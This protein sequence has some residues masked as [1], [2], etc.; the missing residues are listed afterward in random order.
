MKLF[1][2][3]LWWQNI[4]NTGFNV[5]LENPPALQPWGELCTANTDTLTSWYL[6]KQSSCCDG[7][8]HYFET[9]FQSLNPRGVGVIFSLQV[10]KK[11]V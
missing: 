3:C 10:F 1:L 9:Y 5:L 2:G 11:Y 4:E 7:R 6:E 8:E